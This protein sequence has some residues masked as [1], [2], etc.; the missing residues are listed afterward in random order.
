MGFE[1]VFGAGQKTTPLAQQSGSIQGTEHL[2][3]FTEDIGA[4]LLT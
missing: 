3:K 1:V 2:N 4:K